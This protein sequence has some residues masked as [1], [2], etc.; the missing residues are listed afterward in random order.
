MTKA[1]QETV[2]YCRQESEKLWSQLFKEAIK[3]SKLTFNMDKN[4]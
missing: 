4:L 2:A 1:N 3:L